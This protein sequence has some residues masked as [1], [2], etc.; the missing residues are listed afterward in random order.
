[1]DVEDENHVLPG[2]KAMYYKR[3]DIKNNVELFEDLIPLTKTMQQ[4]LTYNMGRASSK[5]FGLLT[6]KLEDGKLLSLFVNQFYNE[7]EIIVSCFNIALNKFEW[8]HLLPRKL[9]TKA[10]SSI[11]AI[12][13]SY[14][15]K[16]VGVGYYENRLNFGTPLNLYKHKKYKMARGV[17]DTHF[18][19][20]TIDEIGSVSKKIV[21]ESSVEFLFP[22]FNN[23]AMVDN[24]HFFYSNSF[25]PVKYIYKF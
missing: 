12:T 21:N 16:K 1:M 3:I 13:F 9:S 15:N 19:E 20:V 14:S 18:I 5:P 23:K 7:A 8:V 17:E 24:K 25:L 10:Y 6:Q 2:R 11:D 22:W 4:N